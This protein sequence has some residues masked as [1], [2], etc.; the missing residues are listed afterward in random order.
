[1][2]SRFLRVGAEKM[3]YIAQHPHPLTSRHHTHWFCGPPRRRMKER[4]EEDLLRADAERREQFLALPAAEQNLVTVIVSTPRG[5]LL[6]QLDESFCTGEDAEVWSSPCKM[7][8][9]DDDPATAAIAVLLADLGVDADPSTIH[10]V[11]TL[12]VSDTTHH[13]WHH[14]F[15]WELPSPMPEIRLGVGGKSH[16]E[17]MSRY[18]V[19]EAFAI[20]HERGFALRFVN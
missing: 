10:K 8:Q 11:E 15:V 12:I 4:V 20:P 6:I 13:Y 16:R 14:V 5:V 19:P 17:F 1:M 2:A 9:P 3:A 7:V 18:T